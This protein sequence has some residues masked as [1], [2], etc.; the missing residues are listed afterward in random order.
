MNTKH[1]P[2]PWIADTTR[3]YGHPPAL[4]PNIPINPIVMGWPVNRSIA[5]VPRGYA[6][7][8]ANALLIAAAPELLG[9]LRAEQEWREREAAGA[10]DPEWDYEVMVGAKR[11]AAIAKATGAA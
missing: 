2:G 3:R 7:A 5:K 11:R 10:I 6:E 9:A 1:T 8:E 4:T